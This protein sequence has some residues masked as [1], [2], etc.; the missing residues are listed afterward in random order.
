MS[1]IKWSDKKIEERIKK[2]FGT[3]TGYEYKPWINVVNGPN[4]SF[5]DRPN[6]WKT[7]RTTQLLSH[8]EYNTFLGFEWSDTVVDIREQYPL[9][10]NVT[11]E[12]A[13]RLGILHPT[14]PKGETKDGEEV[15]IVMTTDLLLTIKTND[16]EEAYLA[17]CV[18]PAAK[19]DEE[20][21]LAKLQIEKTYWEEKGIEWRIITDKD[22]NKDFIENMKK[23][24]SLIN[25]LPQ[26]DEGYF[27]SLSIKLVNG[28]TCSLDDTFL[29]YF[30]EFDEKY[31]LEEGLAIS[32]FWYCLANKMF[33][34]DMFRPIR[35][36]KKIKE[37][38]IVENQ[39]KLGV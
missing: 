24:H 20:R 33:N 10:R 26:F 18:K 30:D 29:D 11:I 35:F 9:Q 37:L 4:G 7:G 27:N 3:G 16:S 2:G 32:L 34:I 6:G 19:L 28:L 31:N 22:L 23:I 38:L 39:E 8:L 21:T 14:Y 36:N 5:R 17:V 15:F 13:E 1:K 25:P 12:I